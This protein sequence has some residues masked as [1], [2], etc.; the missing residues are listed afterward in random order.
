VGIT[1]VSD[2]ELVG[3]GGDDE[4]DEGVESICG[5]GVVGPAADLD[6]VDA[7]EDLGRGVGACGVFA[8][9]HYTA[10]VFILLFVVTHLGIKFFVEVT[11][12]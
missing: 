6:A 9:V 4:H 7:P 1:L 3:I 12:S 8:G 10:G 11:F 5:C 2:D